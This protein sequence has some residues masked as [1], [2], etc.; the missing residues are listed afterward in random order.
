MAL[1]NHAGIGLTAVTSSGDQNVDGILNAYKWDSLNLTYSFP[2][3]RYCYTTAEG[4]KSDAGQPF[5]KYPFNGLTQLDSAQQDEARRAFALI[6]SYTHLNFTDATVT[7]TTANHAVLRLANSNGPDTSATSEPSVNAQTSGDIFFG[8]PASSALGAMDPNGIPWPDPAMGNY[9]SESILHEIGHALGLNHGEVDPNPNGS[10]WQAGSPFGSIGA[11]FDDQEYSLMNYPSYI[12]EPIGGDSSQDFDSYP[13]TY[14]MYD[15]AALQYYYGA[16]FDNIGKRITYS[17]DYTGEESIDV[18]GSGKQGLGAPVGGNIF[19]TVW[20]GGATS[21]YDLHNFSGN[22]TLD[23]RP[24]H[25]M[26]F[27]HDQLALLKD[28]K[29]DAIAGIDERIFAQGNVYN[30]LLY[31]GNIASEID[32]IITGDGNDT[33]WGNDVRN[34]ITLGTG[35]DIVYI[36]SAG[37]TVNCGS[38]QYSGD[39]IFTSFAE[40]V[41]NGGAGWDTLNYSWDNSPIIVNVQT[42]TVTKLDWP[43]GAITDSFNN[44]ESFVGG[45][46]DDTF[47]SDRE[48]LFRG[49]PSFHF[50]GGGGHNTLDYSWLTSLIVVDLSGGQ[51]VWNSGVELGYDSFENVQEFIGGSGNDMFRGLGSGSYT[52]RGGGGINTID[53]SE[54]ASDDLTFNV[55]AGIIEK[56]YQDFSG[57][58]PLYSWQGTDNFT[59]VQTFVGGSGSNKFISTAGSFTFDGTTGKSML[60]YSW[61]AAN[62]TVDLLHG[63]VDKGRLPGQKGISVATSMGSDVFFNIQSFLGGAGDDLFKSLGSGSYS[64]VAGGGSNTLDYSESAPNSLNFNLAAGTVGKGL[65]VHIRP[66]A[67]GASEYAWRDGQ[68]TFTNVQSFVGG[69]GAN[70]FISEAGSFSCNGG[71]GHSTL[72]YSWNQASVT[73]DLVHGTVDKGWLTTASPGWPPLLMY[74]WQGLDTIANVQSFIGSAGNDTLVDSVGAHSFDGGAGVDTAIFHGPQG[75]YSV[76]GFVAA[77]GLWHV[78]VVEKQGIT[79]HG[80]GPLDLINVEYLQFV[81]PD[82]TPD[83]VA[84]PTIVH[85]D[86][87]GILPSNAMEL[88]LTGAADINGTGNDLNNTIIGNSGNN[89]IDGGAGIDIMTGGAGD[90]TYYVDNEADTVIEHPNEGTDVV[91]STVNYTL[92]ANVEVLH[93][94]DGAAAAIN[95]AGN[96]AMNWI[97]GNSLANALSGGGGDDILFGGAGNDILDGGIGTDVMVGGLGDDTYYVDSEADTIIENSNEGTDTVFA[98]INYTLPA[99]FEK[100]FLVEGAAA[101]INGAGNDVMNW[102]YGNSLNNALSGGVGDD[103]LIGGAGNDILDGGAGSDVMVGGVGDDTYYVDS[104]ADTIV[105]N[106][107]EGTDTVFASI[108]YTLPANFEILFLQ[109]GA[110]AAINGAGNGSDNRIYGNSLDNALSG[111]GGNDILVGGAGKDILDGGPGIDILSGGSGK[112]T[113]VFHAGE[114]SGDIVL[115]FSGAGGDGDTLRF[116]GFGTAAQGATFTEIGTSTHWQIHSGLDGHNEI[117]TL[118]NGAPVHVTDC[119]F[120]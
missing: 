53:Y 44:I 57:S 60:D 11:Q 13:E 92:P 37:A 66:T 31:Q 111:G 19:E 30:A 23:M 49:T 27:S 118:Q 8:S 91:Y 73:V 97:Y 116:V 65:L 87:S 2:L 75:D 29:V 88:V 74:S 120:L 113:F 109:E 41:I 22:A 1:D 67:V 94:V 14:M 99:N 101:A 69:S 89:I 47:I 61:D 20:T 15:I 72:D 48:P 93:L 5:L 78:S 68:D 46:G 71:S 50:N 39:T 16:N 80:D 36:G 33:V 112:D 12:G 83:V 115:D 58:V 25:F 106:P 26:E 86:H 42:G 63:T 96:D 100:L 35:S 119:A 21:T 90:D 77:D 107:N 10:G 7:E 17:W 82:G 105:E 108:N 9:G 52:F 43:F 103:I 54:E 34:T 98:S 56:T 38:T 3:G 24:G 102:I 62:L 104:E 114:A 95:G 28:G 59:N 85:M 117:I 45:A 32:N 55:K 81:N 70:S 79:T 84:A 51:V 110:S 76:T 6:E 40:S 4:Y 18:D 64:F